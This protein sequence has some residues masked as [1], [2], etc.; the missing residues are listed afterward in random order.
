MVNGVK[1]DLLL[2]H[3]N[4]NLIVDIALNWGLIELGRFAGEYRQL[5]Q[6]LP[7]ATLNNVTVSC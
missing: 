7:S 5:F 6:E 4:K 2:S 3:P 1:R